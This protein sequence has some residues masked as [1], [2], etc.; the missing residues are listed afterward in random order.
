[1]YRTAQRLMMS[2]VCFVKAHDR[3]IPWFL[4]CVRSHVLLFHAWQPLASSSSFKD[5]DSW[6]I[7]LMSCQDLCRLVLEVVLQKR[8]GLSACRL[9]VS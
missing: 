7:A 9:Q 8:W 3:T 5:A 4:L 2:S 6:L 1:M